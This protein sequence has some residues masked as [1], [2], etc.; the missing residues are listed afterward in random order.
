MPKIVNHDDYRE[1]ILEKSFDLFAR[2]G[3]S[4]VTI[5]QL[6]NELEISTGTLYHYFPN[7]ESVF[8]QM[9]EHISR[10]QV[11]NIVERFKKT[12]SVEERTQA[13]FQY[14]MS[15]E[16]FFQN[17]LLLMIDYYRHNGSDEGN[18]ILEIANYYRNTIAEQIGLGDTA[19]ASMIFSYC[20]G[21]ILQGI[22]NLNLDERREQVEL[23]KTVMDVFMKE[24]LKGV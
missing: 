3:F 15:N 6:A 23:F 9:M 8:R 7:K 24:A 11:N 18:F 4:S 22:L 10:K 2:N 1:E 14:I 5:R 13:M 21:L 16:K 17:V 19:M 12:K 20:L